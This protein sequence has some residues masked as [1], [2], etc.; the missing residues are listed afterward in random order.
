MS[1]FKDFDTAA[2]IGNHNFTIA[3]RIFSPSFLPCEA[4]E[5]LMKLSALV[6]LLLVYS[7]GC[8]DAQKKKKAQQ[9]R[10]E[11][12]DPLRGTSSVLTVLALVFII[13]ILLFIYNIARDPITPTLMKEAFKNISERTF[14]YLSSNKEK[15][16]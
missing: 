7:V 16:R 1:I 13:P 4:F 8:V 10:R 14:G 2:V 3:L 9:P 12:L 15:R 11:D 6:N 5:L